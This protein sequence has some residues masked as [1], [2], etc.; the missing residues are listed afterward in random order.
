MPASLTQILASAIDRNTAAT[1]LLPSAIA[2]QA[3]R[4]R[5]LRHEAGTLWM[6]SIDGQSAALDALIATAEPIK[7]E[8]LAQG[9]KLEFATPLTHRHDAL[10]LNDTQ[11]V[12]AMGLKYPEHIQA[13]QRRHDYRVPV[14]GQSE[15][16]FRF[17]LIGPN[18]PLGAAPDD[19]MELKIDVRDFSAG[20]IGGIWKHR[21]NGPSSVVA[22]QRLRVLAGGKPVAGTE[23]TVLK[24]DGKTEKVKTDEAG[25]TPAFAAAGRYGAWAK[26]VRA[27]AGE[28]GGKKYEEVRHYA[29]LVAELTGK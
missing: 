1:V 9:H 24:P 5:L 17:W 14:P 23:V 10:P 15:A 29:T 11:R 20:G 28:L 21:K 27:E 2:G 3:F 26:T 19:A 6:E 16:N 4:S 13:I 25:L 22:G 18:T 7:I 12:A 8:L